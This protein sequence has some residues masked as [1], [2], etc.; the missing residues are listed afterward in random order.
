MINKVT[1]EKG[2]MD[3]KVRL[4]NPNYNPYK[5]YDPYDFYDLKACDMTLPEEKII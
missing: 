3:E 1:Q 4:K 2:L 5:N